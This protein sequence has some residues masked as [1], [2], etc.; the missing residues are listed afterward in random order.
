MEAKMNYIKIAS[1]FY[2]IITPISING[3]VWPIS[4]SYNPDPFVS[5]YGPRD[6]ND[7]ESFYEYDFHYGMD[8]QASYG[9]LVYASFDGIAEWVGPNSGL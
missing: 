5:A 7:S 9:T 3:Q 2:L 1:F 4:N 6:K 8:L